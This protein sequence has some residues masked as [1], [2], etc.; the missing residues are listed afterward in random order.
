MVRKIRHGGEGCR[1]GAAGR[2]NGRKQ[3][4][5]SPEVERPVEGTAVQYRTCRRRAGLII[6]CLCRLL[7]ILNFIPKA[8]G[9]Q[10]SVFTQENITISL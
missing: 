9:S 3:H 2:K 5:Q 7:G 8:T 6:Y 10:R 4:L 1:G